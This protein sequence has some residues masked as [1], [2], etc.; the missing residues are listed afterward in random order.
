[1]NSAHRKSK[2]ETLG[3]SD[4]TLLNDGIAQLR[5]GLN[6]NQHDQL[7]KYGQLIQKWNRVYNLTAIRNNRELITHHLLDSL[8]VL[9]EISFA[10]QA[11]PHAEILDVGAGAGL[12]GLVLAISQPNWQVTLIDT[13]QKKAAFMQQA[14][15]SLGLRNA[16]AVHGRVEE[17]QPNTRFDLICSRAFSSIDNFIVLGQHLLAENGQ[18]AALKGRAE[19]DKDVPAGWR[20]EAL[21]PIQVPFLDETRHLFLIKR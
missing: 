8:A 15:A 20:I 6:A 3:S 19:V 11:T 17:Y 18:F 4:Q 5:L 14:I 7:F 16:Q 10:L 12:P 21:H 13:V 2:S 9:P 1:M